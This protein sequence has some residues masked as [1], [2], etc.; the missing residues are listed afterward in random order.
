MIDFFNIFWKFW[1]LK[2][3]EIFYFSNEKQDPPPNVKS[4]INYWKSGHPFWDS[5]K[6]CIIHLSYLKVLV[7]LFITSQNWDFADFQGYYRNSLQL[8]MKVGIF[9]FSMNIATVFYCKWNRF[10]IFIFELW[11]RPHCYIMESVQEIR[12]TLQESNAV[13]FNWIRID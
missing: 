7:M 2:K 6:I 5:L 9:Q 12:T 10:K 3:R 13:N 8:T 11:G 1:S 4:W